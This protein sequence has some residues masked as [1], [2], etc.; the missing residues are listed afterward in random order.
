M[1]PRRS[2]T[3]QS[4]RETVAAAPSTARTSF[5]RKPVLPARSA[6]YEAAIRDRG[7]VHTYSLAM[8]YVIRVPVLSDADD[9]A[10]VHVRAW[11]R[12]YPDEYLSALSVDERASMWRQALATEPVPR[13]MRLVGES[14]GGG[15]VGF[16][17]V[18]PEGGEADAQT[19]ELYAI[20]VDPDHWGT[21]IGADLI[22]AAVEALRVAG[23]TTAILWV[24]PDNAR[25]RAFY[26]ARDWTPDEVRRDQEILGVTV[27]EVRHSTA[28]TDAEKFHTRTA[29][30]DRLDRAPD[31]R[32]R[33]SRASP[34]NGVHLNDSASDT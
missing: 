28:L 17:L 33:A 11:M 20:N 24:H 34:V 19:G 21:G 3:G 13:G 25:A 12:A 23:F 31:G 9:I 2:V 29:R 27:P 1:G 22:A 10:R 14:D 18:G 7:P 30:S 4:S 5:R 26:E 15:V 32:A 6:G 8:A 16:A